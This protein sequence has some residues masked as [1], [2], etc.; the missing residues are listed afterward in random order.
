MFKKLRHTLALLAWGQTSDALSGV[1][2]PSGLHVSVPTKAAGCGSPKKAP[3]R[4][5]HR[6]GGH[7]IFTLPA[8]LCEH[9]MS[10]HRRNGWYCSPYKIHLNKLY[11]GVKRVFPAYQTRHL[12]ALPCWEPSD[13][14]ACIQEQTCI[15]SAN[16]SVSTKDAQALASPKPATKKPSPQGG[17]FSPR[18]ICNN[19]FSEE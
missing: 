8:T 14:D 17:F 4:F 1:R 19:R 16:V 10:G 12:S 15:T 9:S 18:Y 7:E 13:P 2:T 6:V 5:S 3:A 11:Q